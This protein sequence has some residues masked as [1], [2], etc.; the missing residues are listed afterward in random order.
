MNGRRTCTSVARGFRT[1]AEQ[2]A[3]AS[4]GDG[5]GRTHRPDRAHST[6]A[7]GRDLEP[8][9]DFGSWMLATF[10]DG[11]VEHFMRPYNEKV[12]AQPASTMSSRWLAERVST[13]DWQQAAPVRGHRADDVTWGPNNLFA[14]PSQGGTGEIYRR[15]AIG[16]HRSAL[17]RQP[18]SVSIDP[19]A[20]WSHPPTTRTTRLRAPGVDRPARSPDRHCSRA[21]PDHVRA[22]AADLVHNSVTVVGHRVRG[23]AQ[24]T[25]GHGCTSPSP[26]SPSTGRRTS[27]STP[28]ATCLAVAPIATAAG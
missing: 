11:I 24:S 5:R 23:A 13:V 25:S 19:H 1:P 6:A 9:L 20:E 3:S 21:G 22:A 8:E 26:T 14:F 27:P 12:W 10:G 17:V 28:P 16:V 18:W 7:T 4:A 15:A 2:P